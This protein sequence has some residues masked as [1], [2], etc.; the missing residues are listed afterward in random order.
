MLSGSNL[1][2]FTKYFDRDTDAAGRI[3]VDV[4]K[5]DLLFFLNHISEDRRFGRPDNRMITEFFKDLFVVKIQ[6]AAS[7]LAVLITGV[8][9]A[10]VDDENNP[11]GD[12]RAARDWFVVLHLDDRDGLDFELGLIVVLGNDGACMP[13]FTNISLIRKR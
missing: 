5:V 12:H 4:R 2:K 7:T 6:V 11:P 9:N 1:M 10:T 8:G 13:D 3:A